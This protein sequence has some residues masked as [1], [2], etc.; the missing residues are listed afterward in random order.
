MRVP[1]S[2]YREWTMEQWCDHVREL[3]V[4]SLTEWAA[5]S[6]S[7]YNR[8]ATLGLQRQVATRLGWKP[9]LENGGLKAMT[10]DEFVQGFREKGVKNLTDMWKSAQHWCELL[11]REGRLKRVAERL[12]CGYVLEFHPSD[13]EYYLERCRRVGDFTAWAQL[14]RNAADA[15]RRNGL[16][17]EV[18]KHAPKRPPQ[19]YPTAGGFCKSLPEL[20]V[21]RLLEANEIEF[22]SEV[23]YPF[24][25]PRGR[26]HRSKSDFYLTKFGAFV[27]VWSAPLEDTSPHFEMYLIRRRLKTELCRRLNLR[28]LH[29]EG[30][31]LFRP[32][33]EAFLE[34]VGAVLSDVGIVVNVKI[35]PWQAL[36]PHYAHEVT[37]NRD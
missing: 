13:L 22:V 27:E 20:A 2:V 23:Q 11:R 36:N 28:L 37:S 34:H 21:A 17:E 9:K 15:A 32:G 8:A 29:I 31:L 19:G 35:D 1:A 12:G 3:G 26:R 14:D 10:D 25:F 30:S 33:P 24:T 18:R 6:R 16:M 4:N 7:S 5:S